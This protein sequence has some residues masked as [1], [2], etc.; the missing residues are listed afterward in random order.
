MTPEE[1]FKI[2][3]RLKMFDQVCSNV[4]WI[5][6]L[7]AVLKDDGTTLSVWDK[8]DSSRTV[9]INTDDRDDVLR[10]LK[11]AMIAVLDRRIIESNELRQRL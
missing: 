4:N 6:D 7:I 2:R 3:S 1:A 10:E 9:Q 5:N 8:R 11:N